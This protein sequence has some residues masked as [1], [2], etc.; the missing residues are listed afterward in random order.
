MP[1]E[2]KHTAIRDFK[3]AANSQSDIDT[4]ATACW[5]LN[6][7]HDKLNGEGV[8]IVIIDNDVNSENK[9]FKTALSEKRLLGLN[10]VP[11]KDQKVWN[12]PG[13]KTPSHGTMA[14]F[15]AGGE[16]FDQVKCGVAPKSTLLICSVGDSYN[17][18]AFEDAL[19]ELIRLKTEGSPIDII[20]MSFGWEYKADDE[21]QRKIAKLISRLKQLNV[22]MIA[23][24]GN[25]GKFEGGVLFPAC[26]DEVICVGAHGTTGFETTFTPPKDINVFAPG[27]D[28]V[29]PTAYYDSQAE[30]S[31]GTSCAAP[32]IAG[33]MALVLQFSKEYVTDTQKREKYRNPV[34]LKKR[35]FGEKMKEGDQ[36]LLKPLK[37]FKPKINKFKL[38]RPTSAP[39][40]QAH[41]ENGMLLL[42]KGK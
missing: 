27:V 28:I 1:S 3:P 36:V 24:A 11:G 14:A 26:L 22:V 34:Y 20:S 19:N 12:T 21:A 15:I 29:H 33:L 35:L 32:A 2:E 8:V 38:K 40:R 31:T 30:C 25:Y 7:I 18:Q 17:L 42:C 23:C 4:S 10:F 41:N 37:F 13:G 5:K 6:K 9:A 39:D 16:A